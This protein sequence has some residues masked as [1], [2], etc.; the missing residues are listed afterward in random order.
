[1]KL[2]NDLIPLITLL[3]GAAGGGWIAFTRK[4]AS[5]G[6]ALAGDEW[7]DIGEIIDTYIARVTTMSMEITK[8]HQEVVELRQTQYGLKEEIS[9][10]RAEN[11]RLKAEIETLRA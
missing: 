7:Q 11:T 8:L 9:T 5:I 3:L 1:M 4:K 10:L 2:L 6:A